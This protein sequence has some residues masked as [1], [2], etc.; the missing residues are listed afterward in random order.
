MIIKKPA[1]LH[2]HRSSMKQ[3]HKKFK[4]HKKSK[5]KI[6][7]VL[8]VISPKKHTSLKADKKNTKKQIQINKKDKNIE[9]NKIYT[10]E[11]GISKLIVLIP[12]CANVDPMKAVQNLNRSVNIDTNDFLGIIEQFKQK[13]QYIIP[14]RNF[15]DIL[16]FC[17]AADFVLL[18]MSATQEVDSFGEVCLRSIQAQ[19]ISTIIPIVQHVDELNSLKKSK[20]VKKSLLS[21]INHFFPEEQ[22]IYSTDH[23]HEAFNIVKMICAQS[24]IGI[25]WRDER[26]YIIAEKV[27]WK[28]SYDNTKGILSI[29]GI[30]RSKPLNIDRLVHIP[31]WGDYQIDRIILLDTKSSHSEMDE[32]LMM[33]Y[34]EKDIILPTENQDSLEE[35][36]PII[37]DMENTNKYIDL[38][39]KKKQNILIGILLFL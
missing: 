24:P 4:S 23:P 18:L 8:H 9:K 34:T 6:E 28:E 31:G 21:F 17:K 33:E 1:V 20:E 22:K 30:V 3:S 36:V 13:L 26:S 12:L 10:G 37:E 35:L 11:S 16:D 38:E 7:T 39:K 14:K 15:L 32:D 27:K 5:K 25:Q 29:T 2:H 19:G